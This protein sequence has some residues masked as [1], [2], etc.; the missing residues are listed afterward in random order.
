MLPHPSAVTGAPLVGARQAVGRVLKAGLPLW[1]G[2]IPGVEP[3]SMPS[4]VVSMSKG[5]PRALHSVVPRGFLAGGNA[6]R[7]LVRAFCGCLCAC[8]HCATFD[9]DRACP[10]SE[11]LLLAVFPSEFVGDIH[12]SWWESRVLVLSIVSW[13]D[14][15][16]LLKL[17][18][19]TRWL[20]VLVGAWQWPRPLRVRDEFPPRRVSR[21][22]C[23]GARR[24]RSATA[25]ICARLRQKLVVQLLCIRCL[26]YTSP[27]PRDS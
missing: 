27:S 2:R 23:G 11:V 26:L 5:R 6:R 13:W 10:I 19:T 3:V 17:R 18:R 8:A 20:L 1:P 14:D 22:V 15:L 16:S 4:D 21:R 24:R 12:D 7:R 25:A 9:N